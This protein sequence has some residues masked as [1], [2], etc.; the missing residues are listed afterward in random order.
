MLVQTWNS[1][2]TAI[3]IV[4]SWNNLI[5]KPCIASSMNWIVF[6]QNSCLFFNQLCDGIWKGMFGD[7]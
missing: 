7:Y 3:M 6:P 1:S 5:D 4:S 2:I